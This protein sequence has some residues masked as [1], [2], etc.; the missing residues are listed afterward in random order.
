MLHNYN[1]NFESR[2]NSSIVLRLAELDDCQRGFPSRYVEDIP[3]PYTWNNTCRIFGEIG[4]GQGNP[5]RDAYAAGVEGMRGAAA[6]RSPQIKGFP[7]TPLSIAMKAP[8]SAINND[9]DMRMVSKAE[10]HLTGGALLTAP[11]PLA[12]A[13][14]YVQEEKER[15]AGQNTFMVGKK[16]ENPRPRSKR[17]GLSGGAVAFNPETKEY[18]TVNNIVKPKFT[19][20][21]LKESVNS[22]KPI[23]SNPATWTPLYLSQAADSK[24]GD[25]NVAD[26]QGGALGKNVKTKVKKVK[27]KVS[28]AK[29]KIDKIKGKFSILNKV[30]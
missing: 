17:A 27:E 15:G 21:Q 6:L 13:L 23:G 24:G 10:Q 4:L 30:L 20:K 25:S 19:K 11:I 29:S 12:H 16:G 9:P 3:Q 18:K 2:E 14:K 7:D 26:S 8:R 5:R 22:R 1:N 28:A